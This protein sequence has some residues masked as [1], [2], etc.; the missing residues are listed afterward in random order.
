MKIALLLPGLWRLN[1][2]CF[3]NLNDVILSKH[4]VDI[5]ISTWNGFARCG[6]HEKKDFES[7]DP[8]TIESLF[9][10]LYGEKIKKFQI[11]DY[12]SSSLT[13]RRSSIRE[14]AYQSPI[15]K[16]AEDVLSPSQ[17]ELDTFWIS[18]LLDQYFLWTKM[19]LK[20]K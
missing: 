20:E 12:N 1:E 13:E 2:H 6:V 5:Y 17:I 18:R 7:T 3:G 14:I 15:F 4:D 9:S 11:F 16:G 10:G 19:R 8:K